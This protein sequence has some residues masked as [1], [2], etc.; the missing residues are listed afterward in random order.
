MKEKETLIT[1]LRNREMGQRDFRLATE[2]LGA[3]LALEVAGLLQTSEVAIQTP[4]S[5]T[6]GFVF[7]NQ[8][9]LVPILR[10]GLA[11]MYPFLRFFSEAKV[12][13]IGMRRDAVTTEPQHYYHNLPQINP[14]DDVLI[15]EPMLAT[16]R[17]LSV[18][19]EILKENGVPEEKMILASIIAAPEG[20]Q[21]M[22]EKFPKI[23]LVI[24]QQDE[25]LNAN[26][27]IV[28]GLGDFG[29]RYFGTLVPST[30]N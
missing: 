25:G 30:R 18:S 23:K 8:I 28:P 19:I 22:Q 13:F 21:V 26:K 7:S 9:I 15:L 20:L 12:G 17:S 1:T 14:K 2:K 27:F 24:A 5:P 29:D 11:L 3:L 4:I 16:G 10:S 6:E